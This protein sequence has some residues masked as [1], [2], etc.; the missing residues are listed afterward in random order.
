[1]C[2]ICESLY[3]YIPA[4]SI[5]NSVDLFNCQH[6]SRIPAIKYDPDSKF[7]MITYT[8]ITKLDCSNCIN[9][10]E[11]PDLLINLVELDCSKCIKFTCIPSTLINLRTLT[12]SKIPN[13]MELP[14][15]LSNLRYLDCDKTNIVTIPSTFTKLDTLFCKKCPYIMEI[16]STFINLQYLFC[17]R[18][19][20]T[21]IPKSLTSIKQ[22]MCSYCPR[23]IEIPDNNFMWLGLTITGSPWVNHRDSNS[24]DLIANV[25]KLK[26]LQKWVK[27]NLRFWIF[28]RWIK[29]EEGVK[30]LY[31]P[32]RIGGKISKLDI[33]QS[34]TKKLLNQSLLK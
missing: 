11:I 16:S 27:R 12:C 14:T 13:L 8:R 17:D 6:V 28:K 34:I 18:T 33:K 24:V 2:I 25:E 20:I 21:K 4:S 26:I 3:K 10:I 15:T 7:N 1:M 22:I 32:D 30:W 5:K 23:L 9:L 19:N 29:S 31:N